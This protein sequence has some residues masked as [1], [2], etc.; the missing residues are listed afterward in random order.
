MSKAQQQIRSVKGTRDLLPSETALWQRIEDEAR[1]VLRAYHFGEI[2]TPLL[3]ATALFARSVGEDTDIVTKEMYTF[4]DHERRDL[5]Q[6]RGWLVGLQPDATP[7][8]EFKRWVERFLAL[9][10]E[11]MQRGEVPGTPDNER[12]LQ[13]VPANLGR[14][15]HPV[16][17]AARPQVRTLGLTAQL[18]RFTGELSSTVWESSC[19]A[20]R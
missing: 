7:V 4:E 16:H 15:N 8:A 10:R 1:R 5:A 11:A 13:D 9:L 3:E 20:T 18:H 12:I 2:R 14:I 6:M 17:G 19:S